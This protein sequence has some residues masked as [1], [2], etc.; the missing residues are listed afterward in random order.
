[1]FTNKYIIRNN[2]KKEG[3][4]WTGCQHYYYE[5]YL[6]IWLHELAFLKMKK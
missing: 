5:K 1:M 4:A 6:A 3:G 2:N